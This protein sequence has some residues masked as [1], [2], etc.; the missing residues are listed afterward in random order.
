MPTYNFE[1]QNIIKI[2][3]NGASASS[4]REDLIDNLASYAYDMIK[5]CTVSDGEEEDIIK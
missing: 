5:D 4:A 1:V 2:R 3:V